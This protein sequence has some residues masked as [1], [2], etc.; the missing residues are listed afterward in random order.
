MYAQITIVGNVGQDPELRYTPTG[1][2][3]CTFSVAVN[4]TWTN[5][6]GEQQQKATWY[7][8]VAFQRQAE[9]CAEHVNQGDRVLVVSENI[10]SSGW[11]DRDGNVRTKIQLVPRTVRFLSPRSRQD[12]P[13]E[14]SADPTDNGAGDE[15]PF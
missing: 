7:S 5:A 6:A 3:M 8:I 11:V 10:E 13:D 14:I 1:T 4:R 9:V 12:A 15:N 2:P